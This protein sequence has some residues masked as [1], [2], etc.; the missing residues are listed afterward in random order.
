M[1]CMSESNN[2]YLIF[3]LLIIIFG[4]VVAYFNIF[5]KDIEYSKHYII[6]RFIKMLPYLLF[7]I[8]SFLLYLEAGNNLGVSLFNGI[9]SFF[10]VTLDCNESIYIKVMNTFA[11]ILLI[12]ALVPSLRNF[13]KL[14]ICFILEKF[15]HKQIY[16]LHGDNNT[17]KI[18]RH[19]FEENNLLV[20][21]VDKKNEK[22]YH[23]FDNHIIAYDSED[24]NMK[25]AVLINDVNTDASLYV[26]SSSCDSTL[27]MRN[28]INIIDKNELAIKEFWKSYGK[29]IYD[30]LKNKSFQNCRI[31]IVGS[32]EIAYNMYLHVLKNCIYDLG[33][34]INI[35]VITTFFDKNNYELADKSIVDKMTNDTITIDSLNYS[36]VF[37]MQES[38]VVIIT[39]KS[40][41]SKIAI[42]YR[43]GQ[44]VYLYDSNFN[45]ED[46]IRSNRSNEKE[47]NIRPFGADSVTLTVE[48]IIDNEDTDYAK[49]AY[50][51]YKKGKEYIYD[52]KNQPI[53]QN[54]INKLWVDIPDN[55]IY[56][57]NS[58][59]CVS[60]YWQF[61]KYIN[62]YIQKKYVDNKKC[63]EVLAMLEHIHWCRV[64]YLEGFRYYKEYKLNDDL[65]ARIEKYRVRKEGT[66]EEKSD[67]ESTDVEMKN[68]KLHNDLRAFD[69]EK[70]HEELEKDTNIYSLI[71][72]LK[73]T[74][75]D[76]DNK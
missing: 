59:Y 32:N 17:S 67:K 64:T 52:P 13:I 53:D 47:N 12:N 29:E 4:L 36:S 2:L 35:N 69:F 57:M 74:I 65:L 60:D 7:Y 20:I 61:R 58:N 28:T 34:S 40:L 16:V 11:T 50:F 38:D 24:A 30:K 48:N 75:K 1:N 54:D 3:S 37:K 27:F 15:F 72:Y 42:K 25:M 10:R 66:E 14:C 8:A 68:Y 46:Y 9:G 19:N 55:I 63:E 73:E 51:G 21:E 70:D 49:K 5:S 71:D 22:F 26:L 41:L 6:M 39:D 31:T 62:E 18:I 43:Y 44:L 23:N 56:N 76:N 45:R 33:Q